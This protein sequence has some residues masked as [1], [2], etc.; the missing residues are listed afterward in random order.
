MT[1]DEI[2]EALHAI[3]HDVFDNE[4]IVLN[5]QTSAHDIPEWDSFNHINILVASEVRFGIHFN[6]AEVETLQCVGDF[7]RLIREKL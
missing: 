7:V 1:D 4:S 5:S 6:T 3:F 2:Y